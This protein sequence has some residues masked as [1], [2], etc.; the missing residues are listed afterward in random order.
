MARK[1]KNKHDQGSEDHRPA[2]SPLS[3]AAMAP[4]KRNAETL[5]KD[6]I[7][8]GT[9]DEK[10]HLTRRQ[11][12]AGTPWSDGEQAPR[13]AT[14]LIEAP[15]S[16]AQPPAAPAAVLPS[17]PLFVPSMTRL[18]GKYNVTSITVTRNCNIRSK[19]TYLLKNI[20]ARADPDG[21]P[22]L[23]VLV[24]RADAANKLVSIAEIA[25]RELDEQN[26]PW[27]QYTQAWSRLEI[28]PP[29]PCLNGD[30]G[31]GEQMASKFGPGRRLADG[32]VMSG[33]EDDV[34]MEDAKAQSSEYGDGATLGTE[35]SGQ[36][37]QVMQEI[38]RDKVKN[39]AILTIYLTKSSSLE[40]RQL[41]G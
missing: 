26:E 6:E 10:P 21:K 17:C 1:R 5:M 3:P 31:R 36:H 33:D 24:A 41:Y 37:F 40:L 32:K 9:K 12:T 15:K 18:H 23:V 34:E 11:K 25:K 14:R 19:V 28:V 8:V 29:R 13:F 22:N 16:Q 30:E 2:H 7:D 39:V 27:C 20:Q 38:E 4:A 35:N